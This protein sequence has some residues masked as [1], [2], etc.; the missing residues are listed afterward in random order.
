MMH[1]FY[2]SPIWM[3]LGF[4]LLYGRGSRLFGGKSK[5][6]GQTS[7]VRT[8][9]LDLRLDHDSGDSS[10]ERDSNFFDVLICM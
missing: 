6:A 8:A 3:V 1:T 5:A 4:P 9:W 10:F 2:Q 7:N